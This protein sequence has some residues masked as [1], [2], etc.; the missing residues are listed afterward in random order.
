MHGNVREWCQDS[1]MEGTLRRFNATGHYGSTNDEVRAAPCARPHLRPARCP[2]SRC[3][4]TGSEDDL[5]SGQQ[6]QPHRVLARRI[7]LR[8]SGAAWP[9]LC[10]WALGTAFGLGLIP[11]D[12]GRIGEDLRQPTLLE[13]RGISL[14]WPP[15]LLRSSVAGRSRARYAVQAARL[16]LSE[17]GADSIATPAADAGSPAS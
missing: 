6:L 13:A 4:D 10:A 3:S 16:P 12:I 9:C 15:G 14:T 11:A 7:A 2:R 17:V 8:N 5:P 1:K